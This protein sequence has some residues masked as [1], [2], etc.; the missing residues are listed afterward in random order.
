MMRMRSTALATALFLACGFASM[1]T[2]AQSRFQLNGTAHL[3]QDAPAQ[4]NA[5]YALRAQLSA[6]T[7]NRAVVQSG[8]RYS[9]FAALSTASLACYNDTIFRDGFDGDGL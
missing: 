4:T 1:P 6:P 7:S 3:S 2:G 9:L 8:A 5:R